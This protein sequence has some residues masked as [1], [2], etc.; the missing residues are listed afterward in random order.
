MMAGQSL[1]LLGGDTTIFEAVA[2]EFVPA[3]SGS[4]ASIALLLAGGPGWEEYVPRYTQPWVRRGVKQIHII[5]PDRDGTL[6]LEAVSVR[7]QE[8]SGMFI[9]GG[10][11]PTYHRLYA[12]EP[13]RSMLRE[14]YQAG[15][16]IAGLSAGA[17]IIPQ[18]CA[19]HPKE[20]GD[21]CA[22][23]TTGLGLVSGLIVGVHF[24][25]R[26]SL[27]H[28]LEAMSATQ[29]ATGLGI[30]GP[31]CAILENGEFK[32]A[33]GESVYRIEM[34]DFETKAYRVIS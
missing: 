20:P 5:V 13:V 21:V 16:P 19:I 29:T 27:P 11:T 22:R 8:T 10:D 33:L 34:T 32:R 6:N 12:A 23:I 15:V 25:E 24:S 2:E 26:N 7:L 14:R 3:A 17:L 18:L 9:G 31:A 4:G 1:F 28:L 30:D